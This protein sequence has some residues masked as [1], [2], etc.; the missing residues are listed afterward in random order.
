MKNKSDN[1]NLKVLAIALLFG[2]VG[3]IGADLLL[4]FYFFKDTAS[5][6]SNSGELNLSSG[7]YAGSNFVIQDPKKVVVNQDLK[8]QETVNA[9]NDSL[10][11]F[12]KRLPESKTSEEFNKADY[13]DL[14]KPEFA[15]MSLTADGWIMVESQKLNAKFPLKDYVA[16]S[17]DKK[18]YSLDQILEYKKQNV[19]MVHLAGANNLLVKTLSASENLS[20]G[21]ML[22]AVNWNNDAALNS[23]VSLPAKQ[24]AVKSSD[25]LIETILL[26]EALDA[27]FKGAWLFGLGGDL[28]ALVNDELQVMPVANMNSAIYSFL[29]TKQFS[30]PLLGVNY[31]SLSN[32]APSASNKLAQNGA[33]VFP[34]ESKVA[35]AKGSPAEKAGI[36]TGDIIISIDNIEINGDHDL[37]VTIQS[38]HPG[39]TV[40]VKYLRKGAVSSA[41]VKL[42]ELK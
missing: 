7:L 30:T 33:V 1:L 42:G 29:K 37:G 20:V 13:Y 27:R 10:V 11:G 21:Q 15:G 41:D 14:S 22:L 18:I 32:L 19:W 8:I 23:I 6:I 5:V 31:I 39:D 4:R 2:I 16:I 25:R 9:A 40:T 3:G 12:F 38:Y 17:K 35:V 28:V 26:G 36:K 34:D 24:Q